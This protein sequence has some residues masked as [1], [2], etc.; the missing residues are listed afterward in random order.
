M[1]RSARAV[2]FSLSATALGGLVQPAARVRVVSA[3]RQATWL[4]RGFRDFAATP[5]IGLSYGA[6]FAAMGWLLT[7]GLARIGME[8]LIL[9]LA[10]GFILIAPLAAAGLYEVSRRREKGL[11]V[12]L[13]ISLAALR[14]N[15]QVADMGLVLLLIFFAWIQLAMV[16]FALF[17]ANRPPALGEF[18]TQVVMAPQGVPFLL[19]GTVIGGVLA[20]LAFAVSV[21]ALPMLL[22]RDVSALA[23]MQASLRAVW[24][25]RVSMIGWAATLAILAAVGMGVLFF[26]LAVTLPIAAHASWHAYRDLIE[27]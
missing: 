26:G 10:G 19:T 20:G 7:M 27:R 16:V 5:M 13:S 1:R 2:P 4:D 8:S 6:A 21:V 15:G 12:S 22:D 3:E 25:N 18:Y 23:A 17:F 11:P 24:C 9:P 14:R